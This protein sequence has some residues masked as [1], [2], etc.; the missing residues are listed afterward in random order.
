MYEQSK[1]GIGAEMSEFDR[2]QHVSALQLA[3]VEKLLN[4]FENRLAA[5]VD[6]K[7]KEEH[8]F[9]NI[10]IYISGKSIITYREILCLS[11]RG[12]P[13]GALSL[14][15]NLYEQN[16]IVAFLYSKRKSSDFEEY[17]EDY[18]LAGEIQR[19]KALKWEADYLRDSLSDSAKYNNQI[20]ALKL[21][22]HQKVTG[23]DYWWT[24]F[25][26]FARLADYCSVS[27]N[28]K[29]Y[30]IMM[31]RLRLMYKL[32]C[33]SL[34]AGSLGNTIRLGVENGFSGIDNRAKTN[35]H[36][37]PLCFASHSMIPIIGVTSTELNIDGSDLIQES[38][39]LSIFYYDRLLKEGIRV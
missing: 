9:N 38:N 20:E 21:K 6:H 19:L 10:L 5:E 30:E 23:N 29:Q 31:K 26:S 13:D 16:I 8:N 28:D 1:G 14:S 22:S 36:E 33:I 12:F 3:R 39:D 34:H 15:R 18:Y 24:G 35:G 4:D 7:Y 32:A 11:S 2:K 37:L 27:E 25:N 17:I